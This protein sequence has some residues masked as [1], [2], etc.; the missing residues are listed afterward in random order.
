[1]FILFVLCGGRK[2]VK[3]SFLINSPLSPARSPNVSG[4]WCLWALGPVFRYRGGGEQYSFQ[5]TLSLN[6]HF[7]IYIQQ[8][9]CYETDGNS[10]H[11]SIVSNNWCIS[12]DVCKV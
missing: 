1:M 6:V 8:L 4:S 7:W 3:A 9:R 2:A 11:G 5:L 12:V 10:G